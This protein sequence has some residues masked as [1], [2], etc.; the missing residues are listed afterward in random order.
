MEDVAYAADPDAAHF[1]AYD[2][3]GE[4]VG[5]ATVFPQDHPVTGEAAWRLRGM[6][7]AEPVRSTGCGGFLLRAVFD[8]VAAEGGRLLWCNAR[9]TALDF[10]LRHGLGIDSE[11]FHVPGGGPHRRMRRELSA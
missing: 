7:V 9:V 5:V 2:A 11:V 8:H 4:V 6:A 10:Y 3:S 1:V